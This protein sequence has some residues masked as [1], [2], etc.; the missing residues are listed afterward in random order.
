MRATPTA[1]LLKTSVSGATYDLSVGWNFVTA[2]GL[3]ITNYT[4]QPKSATFQWSG[5]SGLT[6]G[7]LAAGNGLGDLVELSEEL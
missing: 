4:A 7:G 3:S 1:T 6:F 2:S 5:F